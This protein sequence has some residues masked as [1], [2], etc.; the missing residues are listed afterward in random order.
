MQLMIRGRRRRS[1]R[2]GIS[3][4]VGTFQLTAV[5]SKLLSVAAWYDNEMG[6][7]CRLAETA[8]RIPEPNEMQIQQIA[9]LAAHSR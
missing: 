5:Q 2:F 8:A 9:D 1:Y 7:S 4:S 6:Y 3:G